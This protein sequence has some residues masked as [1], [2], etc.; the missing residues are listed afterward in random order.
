MPSQKNTLSPQKPAILN[1]EADDTF[2]FFDVSPETENQTD[3]KH[4]HIDEPRFCKLVIISKA[5]VIKAGQHLQGC[6][7]SKHDLVIKAEKANVKIL[8]QMVREMLF[9]LVITLLPPITKGENIDPANQSK[10]DEEFEE[11]FNPLDLLSIQQRSSHVLLESDELFQPSLLLRAV[12]TYCQRM[13]QKSEAQEPKP[14]GESDC[15]FTSSRR[16]LRSTH[17]ELKTRQLSKFPSK[18]EKQ[19]SVSKEKRN[20]AKYNVISFGG[21]LLQYTPYKD[22]SEKVMNENRVLIMQNVDE[23]PYDLVIKRLNSVKQTDCLII[24]TKLLQKHLSFRDYQELVKERS[25]RMEGYTTST[26]EE[27]EIGQEVLDLI[28]WRYT[29][30]IQCSVLKKGQD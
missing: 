15:H 30:R 9:Q 5:S 27:Q 7:N 8:C 6:K 20:L 25:D 29:V 16:L 2:G 3:G 17:L 4:I 13:D 28:D 12:M 14:N 18:H 24:G 23:H 19:K 21:H 22:L 26:A 11:I 1:F 10:W